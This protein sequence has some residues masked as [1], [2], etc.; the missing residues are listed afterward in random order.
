[1]IRK[2]AGTVWVD[3]QD[4]EP[5]RVEARAVD[6]VTYGFGMFARIYKGTT[7]VWER[8]KVNGEAWVPARLEIRASARVLLFRRLGLHRITDYFNYRRLSVSAS[9]SYGGAR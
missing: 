8:Q 7:A 2:L 3:E 6:D 4:F 9:S 1:M 5:V